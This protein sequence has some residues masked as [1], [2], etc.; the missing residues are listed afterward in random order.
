MLPDGR[1]PPKFPT[2][3]DL[4]TDVTPEPPPDRH[5]IRV[6]ELEDYVLQG[7]DNENELFYKEYKVSFWLS[8]VR[9]QLFTNYFVF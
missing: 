6:E 2:P 4:L 1:T 9:T 7:K 8:Y 5:P 3:P